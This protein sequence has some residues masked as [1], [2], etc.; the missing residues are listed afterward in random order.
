MHRINIFDGRYW[1]QVR[2]CFIAGKY[3]VVVLIDYRYFI[4]KIKSTS[5]IRLVMVQ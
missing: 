5:S 3:L 4:L 1:H 2:Q